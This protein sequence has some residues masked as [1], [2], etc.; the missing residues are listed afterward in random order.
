LLEEITPFLADYLAQGAIT[1]SKMKLLL[2][3]SATIEEEE[4]DVSN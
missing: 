2:A 3:T 1:I 4:P